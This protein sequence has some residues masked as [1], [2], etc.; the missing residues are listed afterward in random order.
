MFGFVWSFDRHA[1][2]V[3]LFL[4]ELGELHADLFEVQAVQI[5]GKLWPQM[6]RAL[7]AS[8]STFAEAM[9]DGKATADGRASRIRG[10]S[11]AEV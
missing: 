2:V 5:R 4:G 8:A 7:S 6:R 1:E 10:K 11:A 9:V 3:G